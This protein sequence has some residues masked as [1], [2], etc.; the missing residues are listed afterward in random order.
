VPSPLYHHR[1][2]PRP[3]CQNPGVFRRHT[4]IPVP[5][6]EEEGEIQLLH[7]LIG[8]QGGEGDAC[9]VAPEGIQGPDNPSPWKP[10]SVEEIGPD[11]P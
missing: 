6:D 11:T 8:S 10:L 3:T 7:P 4:L 9:P 2:D 5:V 1:L